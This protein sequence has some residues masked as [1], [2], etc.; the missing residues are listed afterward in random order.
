VPETWQEF[1]LIC[2][3]LKNAGITPIISSVQYQWP[4][5]IWFEEMIIGEDPDLYENLCRG[6]AKYTDPAVKK[7]LGVW[8]DMINKGYFSDP[9]A[10]MMSNG[11]YLW[12]QEEY[13][14]V[15]CGTWY[16]ANV[17]EAQGVDRESI[18]AF[19][20]P[21]H[22]P[23]AGKNI[24]FE[25]GP[26][27]VANHAGHSETAKEVADW[28]MGKEGNGYFARM[29][30]TYPGNYEVDTSFLSPVKERL[31]TTIRT[32]NYRILNRYWEAT[33]VEICTVAVSGFG[34]FMLNPDILDRMLAEIQTAADAYW[35]SDK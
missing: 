34:E 26:I 33:P 13:A 17:L 31:I 29:Q 16:Y 3:I 12:T 9:S 4:S 27:F 14:M 6:N 23:Q 22:N 15:L 7:A 2:D 18:G 21:P 10:N 35:L 24:I 30:D 5:F 19:I 1:I 25:A 11:G 8:R 20:L 28:W 32:E